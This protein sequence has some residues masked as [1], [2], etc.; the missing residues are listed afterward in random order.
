MKLSIFCKAVCALLTAGLPPVLCKKIGNQVIAMVVFIA[1]CCLRLP[2][3]SLWL[4]CW[5][6]VIIYI[7]IYSFFFNR[8]K[9]KRTKRIIRKC[10]KSKKNAG[11]YEKVCAKYATWHGHRWA[12]QLRPGVPYLGCQCCHPGHN[13]CGRLRVFCNILSPPVS[14]LDTLL[15][16]LLLLLHVAF[17]GRTTSFRVPRVFRDKAPVLFMVAVQHLLHDRR[18]QIAKMRSPGFNKTTSRMTPSLICQ[19]F[20]DR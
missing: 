4:S 1:H 5:V 14:C 10:R 15:L 11:H 19:S 2:L 20:N 13:S 9:S 18:R 3:P 17:A 12:A 7:Y 16:L 6:V 8:G